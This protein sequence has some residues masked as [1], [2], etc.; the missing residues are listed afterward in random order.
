MLLATALDTGESEGLPC[1]GFERRGYLA[2]SPGGMGAKPGRRAHLAR[3]RWVT[4]SAER[5]ISDA[6]R[7]PFITGRGR[8]APS[9]RSRLRLTGRADAA[10]VSARDALPVNPRPAAYCHTRTPSSIRDGPVVRVRPGRDSYFAP[11]GREGKEKA[12]NTDCVLLSRIAMH[13]YSLDHRKRHPRQ[14]ID[15]TASRDRMPR[16][17]PHPFG[18]K[19][20]AASDR[21]RRL[22]PWCSS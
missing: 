22:V 18:R 13:R 4:G 2:G 5:G 6:C 12:G 1:S 14:S 16:A 19:R 9:G 7:R 11:P 3:G 10:P 17:S 21:M 8:R 15:V 20:G